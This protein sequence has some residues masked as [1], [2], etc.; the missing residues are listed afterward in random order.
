MRVTRFLVSSGRRLGR[1]DGP[2]RPALVAPAAPNAATPRRRVEPRRAGSGRY[3]KQSGARGC[4]TSRRGS[5]PADRAGARAARSR[6]CRPATTAAATRCP[7]R[8]WA[9]EPTANIGLMVTQPIPYPGKRDLRAAVAAREVDAE[10]VQVDSARLSLDCVRVKQAYYRLAY[11]TSVEGVLTRNQEL[12][13]TLLRVA[14][15]RYAV[16][17]GGAAGR[18]QGAGGADASSSCASNA[19]RQERQT[20]EAELNALL[21]RA[22]GNAARAPASARAAAVRCAARD[23]AGVGRRACA[24]AAPRQAMV[25]RATRARSTVAKRDFKPDFAVSGG[26]YYMGSMPAMYMAR[27]DVELPVQRARRQLALAER[28]SAVARVARGVRRRDGA[29]SRPGAGGLPHGLHR[30]ASRAPVPRDGAAAGAPGV[31]V[32]DGE[33]RDRRGRLPVA[34]RQLQQRARERDELLR[35]LDRIPRGGQP[36]RG[37]DR[38]TDSPTET[39]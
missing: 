8:G 18:D 39:S 37:D 33:L 9:S 30:G 32:V 38:R 24:D 10:A 2:P 6:W 19:L 5:A 22:R 23:R 25:S 35:S 1:A 21:N 16:G 20:R 3:R 12:L 7:V 13:D 26:Y 4:E 11:A 14:E 31:R 34:A 36:A 27:F 29:T 17:P 15:S 28:V